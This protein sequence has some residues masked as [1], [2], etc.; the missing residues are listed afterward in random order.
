M[1]RTKIGIGRRHSALAESERTTRRTARSEPDRNVTPPRYRSGLE[2][3]TAWRS[4]ANQPDAS[5][6]GYRFSVKFL[7]LDEDALPGALLS[8]L[9]RDVFL[10]GGDDGEAACP[11]GLAF[12]GSKDRRTLPHIGQTIVE[13]HEDVGRDL[14]AETVSG[15]EILIDPN[16]HGE[17]TPMASV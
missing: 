16:L 14:F 15:A 11:L 3:K 10:S 12:G 8:G 1:P 13:E 9:D 17:N 5:A 2:R 6:L 4:F 7:R